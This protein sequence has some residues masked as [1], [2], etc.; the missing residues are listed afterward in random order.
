MKKITF[1][2]ISN[3]DDDIVTLLAKNPTVKS[4]TELEFSELPD[5]SKS[6]EILMKSNVAANC[7][8]LNFEGCTDI[9]EIPS[10][11]SILKNFK[12]DSVEKII[13]KN[14]KELSPSFIQNLSLIPKLGNLKYL[15][16]SNLPLISDVSLV[17]LS[18]SK[19]I[20]NLTTLIL[21]NCSEISMK[22][23]DDIVR[24]KFVINLEV[25][26]YSFIINFY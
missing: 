22:S 25:K 18:K 26:Y 20:V 6:F 9:H 14:C 16:L 13:L 10:E 1:N 19:Y 7:K 17:F 3:L 15:D 12:M 5:I 4:I 21:D 11:V 8:V 2:S 24:K 23:I